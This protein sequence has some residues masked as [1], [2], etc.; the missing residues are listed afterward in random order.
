MNKYA[1]FIWCL[2]AL[3]ATSEISAQD[4]VHIKRKDYPLTRND[5]ENQ[6]H[7][8]VITDISG[9]SLKIGGYIQADFMYD[10]RD[11][12]NRDAFQPSSIT[13][14]TYNNGG[15]NFSIRQ[16]RLSFS[17]TGPLKSG[18]E[19]DAILEF[20][21]YGPNGTS[22]PRIRHAWISVGEWGF[23]QYWSNFMDSNIWP[24]LVDYWGPNAYVWTRQVQLRF[25]KQLNDA[26]TIAFSVEQPGSDVTLPTDSVNW[27]VRNLYP[28]VTGSYTYSWN[29]GNSHLRLSG[30]LH[31]INY[32]TAAND[33]VN[34]IG[35]AF[36][37]SGNIRTTGNDAFKFQAS[38]GTGYA[39]YSEDISG[40]GYDAFPDPQDGSKLKTSTQLYLWAFYDHWWSQK[41]SST[42]GWGHIKV[43]SKD[44]L[45]ENAISYT[46][47]GAV[48]LLWYPNKYFKTG[49]EV[50]YGNRKNMDGEKGEDLR[51]QLSAFITL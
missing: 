31:P 1:Y 40:L 19:F 13:V 24:N 6:K 34:V 48:N 8:L 44:Y 42:I 41:W 4:S 50:L 22:N 39:R 18:K 32:R 35:G 14:P 5:I 9:I 20:D 25:T 37:F 11:M 12:Q 36:N 45:P 47:Y 46:N 43:D 21:L 23:G 26:N 28:D 38:Y 17:A 49:V 2:V 7:G 15:T 27:E 29:D 30:L 33:A 3:W 16:S 51:I 10:T